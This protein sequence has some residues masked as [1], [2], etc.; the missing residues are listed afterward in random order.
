MAMRLSL[1][2]EKIVI[3]I[4]QQ[5]HTAGLFY[6]V[7]NKIS[8]TKLTPN[9]GDYRLLNRAAVNAFWSSKRKFVLTKAYLLG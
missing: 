6:K 8:D 3:Q 9:A 1:L 7:M 2:L 5:K 4:L